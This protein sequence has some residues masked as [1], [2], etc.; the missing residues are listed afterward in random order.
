MSGSRSSQGILN[1]FKLSLVH[2]NVPYSYYIDVFIQSKK[3]LLIGYRWVS[4][5]K[6][7]VFYSYYTQ[8]GER[9]IFFFMR[10][11]NFYEVK[12]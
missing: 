9:K 7:K 2:S 6:N 4:P 1:E 11:K 3:S 10:E 8:R 12:T 5:M